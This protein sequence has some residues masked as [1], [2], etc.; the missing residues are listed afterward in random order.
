MTETQSIE[1]R[2]AQYAAGYAM[3]LKAIEILTATLSPEMLYQASVQC[4]I[5]ARDTALYDTEAHG[6][7]QAWAD[8]QAKRR[9]AA[10]GWR[11]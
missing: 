3:G 9:Q 8:W 5:P 4:I 2:T 7:S 11:R 10:G 6:A 1:A